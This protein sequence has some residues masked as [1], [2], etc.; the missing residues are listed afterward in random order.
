VPRHTLFLWSVEPPYPWVAHSWLS[1]LA[2]YFLLKIGPAFV[3]A[4]T[5]FG[6][7]AV[8]ALLWKLWQSRAP[9]NLFAP[10]LFAVAIYAGSLRFR[11]RPELLTVLFF[12]VLL[13]ALIWWRA[14]RSQKTSLIWLLA[15]MFAVWANF[16]G[17]VLMG[18]LMLG[19]A[20]LGDAIQYRDA[21]SRQLIF[22]WGLCV[23]AM[24]FNPFGLDYWRDVVSSSASQMFTN[25]NEWKPPLESREMWPYIAAEAVLVLFAFVAWW[26]NPQRRW[27]ELLWLLVMSA[28]FLK[29]RRHL[30]LL[31][32]VA[33]AVAGSSAQY[34]STRK[35]WNWWR[36]ISR[37]TPLAPSLAFRVGAQCGVVVLLWIAL[38]HAI[39]QGFSIR[40]TAKNLPSAAA[41][42]VVENRP[43][44]RIFSD[45]ESSSYFQWRLNGEQNN[46]VLAKGRQP[47]YI[48]LLNAY[49]ASLL[50]EYLKIWSW[51][52][53]GQKAFER[54]DFGVVMMG[55]DKRKSKLAKFLDA[56]PQWKNVV[57]H[58][59]GLVWLRKSP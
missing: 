38:A 5:I 36:R 10:L 52:R 31:A 54:R 34:L 3:V 41:D 55:H 18:A 21:R 49:P 48:D 8:F 20:A 56:S 51:E 46:R 2:Y 16:H 14:R 53:A 7:M 35:A 4:F 40:A 42:F 25:I 44:G 27:S 30:W 22:V 59:N 26:R 45:Y 15:P 23:A 58:K 28:L 6:T 50:D 13:L 43:S 19:L 39:P 11:P 1:Q 12:T 17:A 24:L 37:Q 29:Q 57:R 47:L 32:I 33:L 9:G